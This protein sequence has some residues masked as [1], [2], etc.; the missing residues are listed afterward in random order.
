MEKNTY[1]K[2]K[3]ETDEIIDVTL[4]FYRL[5]QLKTKNP[6]AYSK[7]FKITSKGL[8]D[9]FSVWQVIYTG[10][11]CAHIDDDELEY[12]DF[13]SF[14]MDVPYSRDAMWNCYLSLMGNK[15]KEVPKRLPNS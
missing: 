6:D 14:L 15:K 11:L 9:E 1:F 2:L 4:N 8:E 3:M 7:Y 5:Y 12:P 13:E 10:Y